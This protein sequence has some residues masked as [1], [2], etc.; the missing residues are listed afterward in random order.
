MEYLTKMQART[1]HQ[2]D[3]AL[4]SWPYTSLVAVN[5]IADRQ[6][7]FR[8]SDYG[9]RPGEVGHLVGISL[10]TACGYFADWK[11]AEKPRIEALDD[12]GD[13]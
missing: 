6:Q 13:N 8:A 10:R 5:R 11:A 7:A 9:K 4:D 2:L 3:S 1:S 12:K